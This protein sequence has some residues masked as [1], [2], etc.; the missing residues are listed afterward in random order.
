MYVFSL[1]WQLGFFIVVPVVLF[2]LLGAW[3]DKV[4]GLSPLFVIVLSLLG[5]AIAMHNVY[6][7]IEKLTKKN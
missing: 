2:L 6:R 4:F 7:M 3:L 5:F 1:A